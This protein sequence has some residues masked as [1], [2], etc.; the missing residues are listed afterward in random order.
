MTRTYR[1]IIVKDD[2]GYH[3]WVPAL[4]GCHTFGKTVEETQKNLKE[5]IEGWLLTREDRNWPIPEDT[6][7][8]TLQ[9]VTIPRGSSLSAYA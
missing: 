3:G 5:A 4:A 9:T 7:I 6:L 8:E 2:A 1:T